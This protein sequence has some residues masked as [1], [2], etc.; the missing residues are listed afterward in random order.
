[1]SLPSWLGRNDAPC[2]VPT[3]RTALLMRA[4]LCAWLVC[5]AGSAT[6]QSWSTALDRPAPHHVIA[7]DRTGELTWP[8]GQE[9]V[10]RDGLATLL[11]DEANVDLRTVYADATL[12]QLFVRA[13]VVSPRAPSGSLTAYFFLDVD[14]NANSGGAAQSEVFAPKL[15]ADPSDGGYERVFAVRGDGMVVGAWGWVSVAKAWGPLDI[16]DALRGEVGSA[17]DPVRLGGLDRGY[18]QLSVAHAASGLTATC[19]GRIFVRLRHEEGMR[20]LSD[21]SR[22]DVACRAPLDIYGDP[23][24]VRAYRCRNDSECPFGGRCRDDVCLFAYECSGDGECR[25]GER[26]SDARCVRVVDADCTSDAAC[27]GLV[28]EAGRCVACVES[29]SASC[30]RGR[31]CSP[32]GSCVETDYFVPLGSDRVQGGAFHCAAGSS[33]PSAAALLPALVALWLQRRRHKG[34]R[35][36]GGPR[37]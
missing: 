8:Y 32:N 23:A 6:A 26:C 11:D 13:Y 3:R 29:G 5:P 24:I 15:A 1:M 21:D 17:R 9:D 20:S 34:K 16:T 18:V 10:A 28:C 30:E 2:I 14:G 27:D 12:E 36:V 25:A 33:A 7:I 31:Y 19:G 22:D 37:C 4:A 35:S